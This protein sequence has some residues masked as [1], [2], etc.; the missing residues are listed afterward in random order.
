M[1][2]LRRIQR[3]VSY[4]LAQLRAAKRTIITP[5]DA[6][7]GGYDIGLV[8]ATYNRPEYL[9]QMF[10]SLAHSVLDNTIVA[11]VDDASSSVGTRQLIR[12]LSLGSTPIVRIFRTP[13]RGYSVHEALRDGWDVLAHDYGCRLLANVDADTIMKPEWLHRLVEVF[14]RERGRQGPLIV[15]GFNS[16]QH[17]EIVEMAADYCRK[18]SIGGLNMLFDA[19]L[20]RE[21]VRPALR[22]EPMSQVGWDWH[23]VGQ[24]QAR[25]YPLLC[26][27]PSMVQ[28]IGAVGQFSRPG[29]Y[30]VADDY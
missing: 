8:I 12:D 13:R 27:R 15:T 9:R 24:M 26:V 2:R 30:D 16:H 7:P 11:I 14:R 28:H 23:V 10:T 21:V 6:V 20:Y 29:Q 18:S 22:Y 19:D 17:N 3:L 25:G 4:R 5:A 1:N